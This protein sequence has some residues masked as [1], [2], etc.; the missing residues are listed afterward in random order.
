MADGGISIKVTGIEQLQA[1]LTKLST[2]AAERIIRKALRKGAMIERDAV[3]DAAP[4]R[5]VLPSGTALPPGALAADITVTVNKRTDGS[6]VATVKPGKYTQFAATMVE[7]GHRMVTGG[8]SK[9]TKNGKTRG[10]G[11]EVGMVPAHPF[12]RPVFEATADQVTN[13]ICQTLVDETE[14]A[15]ANQ[16][17]STED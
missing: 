9:K 15:A 8:Y 17:N 11:Q 10:P 4:V 5:P 2:Q 7:Y 1:N 12:L 13:V 16:G 3:A 14:K 6:F